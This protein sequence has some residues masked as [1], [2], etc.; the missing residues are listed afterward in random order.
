MG[1]RSALGMDTQIIHSSTASTLAF[2]ATAAALDMTKRGEPTFMS[3]MHLFLMSA[4]EGNISPTSELRA[5]LIR[6][7]T[8][9]HLLPTGAFVSLGRAA[10]CVHCL[11]WFTISSSAILYWYLSPISL[12]KATGGILLKKKDE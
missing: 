3:G 8:D 6:L 11:L 9:L 4:G 5:F 12:K 10:L 1:I 2:D 7:T